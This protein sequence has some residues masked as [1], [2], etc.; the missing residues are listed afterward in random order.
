MYSLLSNKPKVLTRISQTPFDDEGYAESR[1][2]VCGGQLKQTKTFEK[3]IQLR[4]IYC[5]RD[6]E[7]DC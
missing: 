4:V 1:Y 2:C 3:Y 7:G 6:Q 5:I